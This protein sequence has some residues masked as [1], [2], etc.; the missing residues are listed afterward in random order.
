MIY[1]VFMTLLYVK[2]L[3]GHSGL[4]YMFITLDNK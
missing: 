2:H 1:N 3:H 4:W